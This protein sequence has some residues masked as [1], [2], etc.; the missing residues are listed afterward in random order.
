MHHAFLYN[1]LPSLH[2]YGVKCL[3]ASFIEE[4]NKR[5]QISFSLSTLACGPQEISSQGNSPTLAIFS[6]LE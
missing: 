5:R 6:K 1:S 3:I 2:D 4:V